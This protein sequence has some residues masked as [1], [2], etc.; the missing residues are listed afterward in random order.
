MLTNPAYFGRNWC[1]IMAEQEEAKTTRLLRMNAAEWQAEGRRII[2]TWKG[3]LRQCI[4]YL[5]EMDARRAAFAQPQ[6]AA[7]PVVVRRPKTEFELDFAI[8]KDMIEEPAKYG[9]DIIEWLELDAK[10]TRGSGRWRL[11]AFWLQQEAVEA[12]KEEAR[13]AFEEQQRKVEAATVIQAAVRGHIARS[14]QTFRDCCMC[15]S[16]RI[17]P[18]VTD[19]GRMCRGCAEQGPYTEETGPVADPWSE[20]R[21]DYVDPVPKPVAPTLCRYC[22]TALADGRDFCDAICRGYH[23]DEEEFGVGF[24]TN[25]PPR[26]PHPAECKWCFALLEDDAVAFCDS[27]CEYDYMKEAWRESRY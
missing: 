16:H 18:L 26:V 19:V 9:D 20:F 13:K 4:T 10:L 7:A 14:K 2:R 3:D 5:D 6:V 11:A 1:D 25:L 17:S 22:E 23:A 21:A 24:D 15:L 12:E 27:D 8:W